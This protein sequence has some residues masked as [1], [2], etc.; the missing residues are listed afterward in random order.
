MKNRP[1]VFFPRFPEL[2]LVSVA[3]FFFAFPL[4]FITSSLLSYD[5][6]FGSGEELAHPSAAHPCRCW[7]GLR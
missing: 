5:E 7:D 1:L 3:L 2:L 6:L 4:R